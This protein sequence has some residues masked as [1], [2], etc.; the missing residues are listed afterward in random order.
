MNTALLLII[1]MILSL[2]LSKLILGDFGKQV[3]HGFNLPFWY[4][5]VMEVPQLYFIKALCFY[6]A[7]HFILWVLASMKGH[8]TEVSSGTST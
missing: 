4:V 1:L 5:I 7:A 2:I 6:Y 3:S 8:K